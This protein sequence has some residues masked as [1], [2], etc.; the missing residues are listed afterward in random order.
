MGK[1]WPYAASILLVVAATVI[2][3]LVLGIVDPTNLV[4][5]YLLAVVISGLRWGRD[6]AVVCAVLGVLSFDFFLVPP[7]LTL[8]VSDAQYL[9]TF[10]ALLVV[11]VAI[12]T[13]TGQLRDRAAILRRRERET[14]ALYSFSRSMVA[15]RDLGAL[16]EAVVR[17]VS[18]TFHRPVA[19][20]LT[21][22]G[23]PAPGAVC[24]PL[25]T[26]L[27]SVG[28]L[29]I[30]ESLSDLTADQRRL[31]EAFAVQAAVV[32]ER[33]ELA[34][35]AQRALLLEETEKLQTALLHSISHSLRTPLAS[36]IGS[37]STLADRDRELSP[38]VRAELVD[39]AR[40]EADRLNW[41]V[42]NLLDM[43]RLESG[44]L[45]L[46]TDWNDLEDVIGVSLAQTS[47][48]LKDRSVEV[49]T[50][51]GLP[52]VLL[53][54]GLIV[55]VLDNL[56][57]NAAKYSPAGE[58]VEIRVRRCEDGVW[59]SVADRGPGIPQEDLERVF[60]KFYRVRSLGGPPGTGLGL[61]I[62][63]GIV[64]AH[65]GRIWAEGRPGGGTVVT[66]SLPTAKEGER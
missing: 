28:V 19:L 9:L 29:E 20:R 57:A 44:H 18:E 39:T 37:L 52:L 55:Q 62:C 45:K 65:R 13:L 1:W 11:A 17:H 60:D 4:M 22:E 34:E 23:E 42:S 32:V 15:A 30:A 53:D 48:L 33:S 35:S 36:V 16:K 51:E 12:G 21:D 64:E 26:A 41:L 46:T 61:T 63:R 50:E 2:G 59:I 43:T 49:H 58:P 66:F 24:I 10:I 56:L 7:Y 3:W 54:Q 14:A 6:S 5:L 47:T 38:A 31:L 25:T 8:A 27:G 40:E